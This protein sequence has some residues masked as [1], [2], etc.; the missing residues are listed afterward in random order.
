MLSAFIFSCPRKVARPSQNCTCSEIVLSK[1]AVVLNS[2]FCQNH[3]S[4][5]PCFTEISPIHKLLCNLRFVRLHM[6]VEK[7]TSRLRAILRPKRHQFIICSLKEGPFHFH[8]CGTL[9]YLRLNFVRSTD[10][11]RLPCSKLENPV[12]ELPDD[13]TATDTRLRHIYSSRTNWR[14]RFRLFRTSTMFVWTEL[15]LVQLN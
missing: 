11:K 6:I 15:N 1:N 10:C 9:S 8:H 12:N 4:L 14:G 2:V 13:K 5:N 7:V 3:S